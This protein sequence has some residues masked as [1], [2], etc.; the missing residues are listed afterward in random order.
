MAFSSSWSPFWLLWWWRVGN[1]GGLKLKRW[2]KKPEEVK[3]VKTLVRRRWRR[4]N[5]TLKKLNKT[6]LHCGNMFKGLKQGEGVEP[7]NF[8]AP[9]ATLI[10]QAH[11]PV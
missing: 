3:W 10:T 8:I 7:L 1:G 4:V 6:K 2:M 9:I 5:M 11:T